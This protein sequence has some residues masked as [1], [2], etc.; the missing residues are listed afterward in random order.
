[1]P[2]ALPVTIYS[3]TVTDGP[4]KKIIYPQIIYMQNEIFKREINQAIVEKNQELIDQQID[5]IPSN[6]EEMIGTYDIKNNQRQVLSFAFSN[7]T[8]YHQAAHGLTIIKSLTFDLEKENTCELKD[9]F[10]TDSDYIQKLSSLIEKQIK[11]RDIPLINDFT[12]ITP[13]QDFYIA[14]KTI[15]IYFQLYELTPYVFGFPMFPISLY[16]IQDIINED[17]PLGRLMTNN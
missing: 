10:K 5:Q 7:Y 17:G 12:G 16:D 9:L 4:N 2:I 8:Y 6:V 14:D 11:Q 13:N 15:V 3:Y 1:M